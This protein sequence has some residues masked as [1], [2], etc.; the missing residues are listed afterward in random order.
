MKARLAVVSVVALLIFVFVPQTWATSVRTGSGYGLPGSPNTIPGIGTE[1]L[2]EMP[3]ST[4]WDLILQIDP[5]SPNLGDDLQVSV[6]LTSGSGFDT[7]QPDTDLFG[8]IGCASPQGNL[9]GNV[10]GV[11]VPS[12]PDCNLTSAN[13]N[14][15]TI[16]LPGACN[17]ANATFYFDEGSSPGVFASVTPVG[18]TVAPEPPTLL[19][20][21]IALVP[22]ALLSG[23]KLLA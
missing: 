9:A 8:L 13:I 5:S 3:N 16:T 20:I 22:L 17:V 4:N 6:T 12:I 2:I 10:C 21:A 18:A 19:L 23:R 7:L 15:G 11:S 1:W 14:G